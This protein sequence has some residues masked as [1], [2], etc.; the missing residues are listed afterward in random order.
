MK[1]KPT[2]TQELLDKIHKWEELKISDGYIVVALKEYLKGE[3]IE[4]NRNEIIDAVDK[5]LNYVNKID[6]DR[7]KTTSRGQ[8]YYDD[9]FI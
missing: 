1:K 8:Q 4:K 5:S 9:N 3:M 6:W 7:G 2:S